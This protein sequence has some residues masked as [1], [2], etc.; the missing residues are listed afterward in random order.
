[1]QQLSNRSPQ[2]GVCLMPGVSSQGAS[3]GSL[4]PTNVDRSSVPAA[5]HT[6]QSETYFVVPHETLRLCLTHL[7]ECASALLAPRFGTLCV[8]HGDAHLA[9]VRLV[10]G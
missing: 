2:F 1:M 9:A 7:L 5:D 10:M 8:L 4:K 3:S 6:L